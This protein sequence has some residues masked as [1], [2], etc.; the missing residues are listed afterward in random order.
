MDIEQEQYIGPLSPD[1]GVRVLLH[2]QGQMIFP[3]EEGF[4]V[5]PG[6]S[7]SVG[8]KKVRETLF[9]RTLSFNKS[10]ADMFL[11]GLIFIVSSKPVLLHIT[12]LSCTDLL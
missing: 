12:L 5:S 9:L 2:G 1:A 3:Y 8:I 4:S 10:V 7:T 6:V 11:S